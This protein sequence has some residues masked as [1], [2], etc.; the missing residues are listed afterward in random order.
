M[1][2]AASTGMMDDL[3]PEEKASMLK[4]LEVAYHKTRDEFARRTSMNEVQKDAAVFEKLESEY[5][6]MNSQKLLLEGHGEGAEGGNP[7]NEQET[8]TASEEEN[9]HKPLV[10]GETFR[11][12]RLTFAKQKAK[13]SNRFP[14]DGTANVLFQST[15]IGQESKLQPPFP[16]ELLGT[17]SCHGMEPSW[18]TGGA[19]AKINQDRGCVVHPFL[20]SPACALFCVFDGH[21]EKGDVISNF[22]MNQMVE[23]LAVHPSTKND[24]EAALTEVFVSINKDLSKSMGLTYNHPSLESLLPKHCL[25]SLGNVQGAEPEYSGTT[26]VVIMLQ[27]GKLYVAS[28]GDSRAVLATKSA[29]AHQGLQIVQL[30]TDHNPNRPEEM[31]RITAAGGFV[32]PPPEP[33]LS[34]RV[35]LD[36]AMTQIGLAMARS[37]GDHAVKD[38]GVV[39]EPEVSMRTLEAQD[40][41]IIMASD[42]VW[43]FMPNEKAV[44]IVRSELEQGATAKAAC[45]SLIFEAAERWQQQ[46]GDYRDDITAVVMLV[47][48]TKG[49]AGLAPPAAKRASEP[50]AEGG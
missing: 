9:S 21:G 18:E 34:S 47:S 12:R 46:E 33:G 14:L 17:Y 8:A 42:G 36:K 19:A 28:V 48:D 4:K 41:F 23:R 2:S 11:K 22:A 32:S 25:S 40:Q 20:G 45:E 37:L 10:K 24:P 38:I 7:S 15:E 16:P 6:S 1:G 30:T 39:A 50:K 31:Q 35:W 43:E 13:S 3:P 44:E 5:R 26:A 49:L 29:Q 27:F